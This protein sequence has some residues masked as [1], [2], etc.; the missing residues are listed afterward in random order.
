VGDVLDVGD[1]CTLLLFNKG[2]TSSL[3]LDWPLEKLRRI[4][5]WRQKFPQ[6]DNILRRVSAQIDLF[7]ERQ[8]GARAHDP[9]VVQ[10][11]FGRQSDARASETAI[12]EQDEL[13]STEDDDEVDPDKP[14]PSRR[15]REAGS[16]I[17]EKIV[18]NHLGGKG[19]NYTTSFLTALDRGLFK[20]LGS[21]RVGSIP[22]IE[23]IARLYGAVRKGM[24]KDIELGHV[25]GSLLIDQM[26]QK[27]IAR[28][29]DVTEHEVKNFA[30]VHSAL[31]NPTSL[32]VVV[33]PAGGAGRPQ[34]D[35]GATPE[36]QVRV[37]AGR[38]RG[39]EV[40][41]REGRVDRIN[42]INRMNGFGK[43]VCFLHPVDPVNP[44]E[45]S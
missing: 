30:R 42:R 25:L 15:G 13:S 40:T 23:N 22:V 36:L 12:E 8:R 5:E 31:N 21:L 44:V 32:R 16:V 3:P 19:D 39:V 27:E 28:V 1:D 38:V 20:N 18:C 35:A 45:S 26:S 29:L 6:P 43:S 11:S 33:G 10:P 2:S 17:A 4:V 24:L 41:G 9:P 7:L 37:D 14:K 34:P